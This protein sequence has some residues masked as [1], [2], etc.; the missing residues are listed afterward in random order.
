MGMPVGV[1][2]FAGGI[3]D[4]DVAV[5]TLVVAVGRAGRRRG[6]GDPLDLL[7]QRR[8]VVLDLNDQGDAGFC[9]DLEMFF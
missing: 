4:G 6:D 9:R 1:G 3:E 5:A 7:V 8:L 2:Q